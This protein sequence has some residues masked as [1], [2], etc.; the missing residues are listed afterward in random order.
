MLPAAGQQQQAILRYL[1]GNLVDAL[2]ERAGGIYYR[3]ALCPQGIIDLR[4]YPVGADHHGG[5]GGGVLWTLYHRNALPGQLLHHLPVM[6]ELPQCAGGGE[7]STFLGQLQRPPHPKAEP[8]G[9]GNGHLHGTSP[10]RC[11][12]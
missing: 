1:G 4:S 5:T 6:D 11:R 9:F 10:I 7:G 12:M 2:D 8:G 3:A